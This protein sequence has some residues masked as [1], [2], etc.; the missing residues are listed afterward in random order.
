MLIQNGASMQT[1]Q[2][3][4]AALGG[5]AISQQQQPL[6]Q[7]QPVQAAQ[8]RQYT[9]AEMAAEVLKNLQSMPLTVETPSQPAQPVTQQQQS[10]GPAQ[11][12]QQP[13]TQ[14]DRLENTMTRL[15]NLYE[16]T[17]LQNAMGGMDSTPQSP[18][19][20]AS[21]AISGLMMN[22]GVR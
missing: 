10:Q 2:E 19:D 9:Q 16:R 3:V 1:L 11:A 14:L 18:A 4:S 5:Y 15:C 13:V 22:E 20:I 21:A 7:Q 8:A 12:V 6:L 17:L